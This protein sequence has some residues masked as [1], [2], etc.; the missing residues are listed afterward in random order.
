[1]SKNLTEIPFSY[2]TALRP[3]RACV[4]AKLVQ[5][6]LVSIYSASLPSY[7][8]TMWPCR[9]SCDARRWQLWPG[10][11]Q[12]VITAVC[13]GSHRAHWSWGKNTPFPERV[14]LPSLPKAWIQCAQHNHTPRIT[15]LSGQGLF[16]LEIQTTER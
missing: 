11:Q 10:G 16:Q 3:A 2:V 7:R 6:T 1:M 12:C 4:K 14:E 9:R 15:A 13:S 8:V 5:A